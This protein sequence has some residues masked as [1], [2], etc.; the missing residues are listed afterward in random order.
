VESFEHVAGE[1]DA[2]RP[3]YPRELFDA[4]GSLQGLRT[5]DAGAGTGIATRML[6]E[7]GAI[8]TAL[9]PGAAL[10]EIAQSRQ[11]GLSCV[12]A[13]A[14]AMPLRHHSFD[15]VCFA[16][17]WHW[18]NPD[19][20]CQEVHRILAPGGRWAGWWSHARA[21]G[22]V[23]FN[24]H[25]DLVESACKADRRQRDIDW[26]STVAD[27]RMFD[28]GELVRLPWQRHVQIEDWRTDLSSHSYIASL[29]ES[30]REQLL[31][32]LVRIAK[33]RFR[34]GHMVIDYETWMWIATRRTATF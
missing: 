2:A 5:L 7:R 28:V 31:N 8:V 1:Y 11:T 29:N 30:G 32:D 3:S 14:A 24:E 10:L 9:D 25:W 33:S 18:V 16:Q 21:D 34:D 27:S 13:D 12:A 17:S 22:E 19:S 15:L 6:T 26:G 23:W 4:L 20:R